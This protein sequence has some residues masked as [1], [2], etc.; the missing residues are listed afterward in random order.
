MSNNA[1]V[2]IDAAKAASQ[3]SPNVGYFDDA[4]RSSLTGRDSLTATQNRKRSL[5]EDACISD[6]TLRFRA[7]TN[8]AAG[9][10]RSRFSGICLIF[11]MRALLDCVINPAET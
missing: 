6:V 8:G 9:Q 1:C 3:P 10:G 7:A 2:S 5:T 11:E 4:G